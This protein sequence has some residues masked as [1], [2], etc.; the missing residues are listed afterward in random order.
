M[1][2]Y[3]TRRIRRLGFLA[4]L[5][6]L[7]VTR[8]PWDSLADRGGATFRRVERKAQGLGESVMDGLED[9]LEGVGRGIR[10]GGN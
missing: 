10:G 2:L 5:V 7:A 6:Y 8:L 1:M 9:V 4:L 3:S